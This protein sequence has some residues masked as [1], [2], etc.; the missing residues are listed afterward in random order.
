MPICNAPMFGRSSHRQSEKGLNN[1][2]GRTSIFRFRGSAR[3]V[4]C[5]RII[6]SLVGRIEG[7]GAE[8]LSGDC[9]GGR[10]GTRDVAFHW[11]LRVYLLCKDDNSIG[12]KGPLAKDIKSMSMFLSGE[13]NV[14]IPSFQEF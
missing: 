6:K 2:Y 9:L 3:H 7:V 5:Y 8:R 11:S 13:M 14:V 12:E 4:A 10:K 1:D